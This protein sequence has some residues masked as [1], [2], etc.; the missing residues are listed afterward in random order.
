M[1]FTG[2]ARFADA[3]IFGSESASFIG[4]MPMQQLMKVFFGRFVIVVI[5]VG[6]WLSALDA[7]AADVR[8]YSLL[9]GEFL[10]QTSSNVVVQDPDFGFSIV[11]SVDLTDFNLVTNATLRVPGSTNTVS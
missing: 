10:N 7:P 3:P 9:K 1:S 11:A 2:Q 5:V 4:T 6:L 8:G